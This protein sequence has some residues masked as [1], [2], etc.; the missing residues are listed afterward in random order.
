MPRKRSNKD[1]YNFLIDRGVY[2]DFSKICEEEGFVRSKLVEK[3]MQKIIDDYKHI[4]ERLK[5][6]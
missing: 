6:R 1:R 4:L 2:D 3:A 5:R